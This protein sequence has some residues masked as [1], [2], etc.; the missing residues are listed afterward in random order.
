MRH[1]VAD[2]ASGFLK[3]ERRAARTTRGLVMRPGPFLRAYLG[4]QRAPYAGPVPYLL[5]SLAAALVLGAILEMSPLAS[6]FHDPLLVGSGWWTRFPTATLFLALVVPSIPA[7]WVYGWLRPQA[8][9]TAAERLVVILYADALSVLVWTV[10]EV[11]LALALGGVSFMDSQL[12]LSVSFMVIWAWIAR[13][14]FRESAWSVTWKITV[15]MLVVMAGAALLG[16]IAGVGWGLA[17]R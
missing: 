10:A 3:V 16:V 13:P 8:A 2:A 7:A 6:L 1:L 4:G 11:P 5:L 17:V 14:V 9:L 12:V 15:A